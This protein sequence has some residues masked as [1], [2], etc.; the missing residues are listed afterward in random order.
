MH[1]KCDCV[2]G[3]IIDGKRESFLFSFSL[4]VRPGNKVFMEPSSLLFKKVNKD[5]IDEISFYLKDDDGH[6]VDFNGETL[7][8]GIFLMKI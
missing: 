3:S 7:T 8:F 5:K 2:D 1:L 4:D 6:Q